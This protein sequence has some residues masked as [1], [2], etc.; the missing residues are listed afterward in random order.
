MR[1]VRFN[2]LVLAALIG[3]SSFHAAEARS[4]KSSPLYNEAS[5]RKKPKKAKRFKPTKYKAKK[6]KPAKQKKMKKAKW[7]AKQKN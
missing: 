4:S 2:T 5:R 7:G 1:I 6:F 3:F